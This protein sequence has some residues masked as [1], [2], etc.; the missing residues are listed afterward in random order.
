[1]NKP[2]LKAYL[3]LVQKLL[4]CPQGEEWIVL[5]QHGELVNLGLV[6]VMEQVANYFAMEGK[7][8]A[9]KYLHNWA[10][11]LHHILIDD[12]FNTGD[13]DDKINAYSEL[14]KA[15]L[16]CPEGLEQQILTAHQDL[17]EP[18]LIEVMREVADRLVSSE[19]ET[20]E[21]LQNMAADLDRTWLKHHEFTPTFK[22]EIIPDPWLD[23]DEPASSPEIAMPTASFAIAKNEPEKLEAIT[24]QSKTVPVEPPVPEKPTIKEIAQLLKQI[25][26]SLNRLETTIGKQQQTQNPLWYME[27]L[28]KA[29]AAEWILTTHEVEQLIGVKPHCDRDEASFKRGSWIFEKAGKIGAQIAWKVVK[30]SH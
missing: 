20:A 15:L 17:I 14:I 7:T 29:A 10:S 1:M 18:K 24:Q 2:S 12:N 19:P 6:E 4:G 28:E 26:D 21:Y 13:K 5:R 27:V 22:P 8:K 9:A 16:D 11:Q 25:A 3:D 23:E 30:V